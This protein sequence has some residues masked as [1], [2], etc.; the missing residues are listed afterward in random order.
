MN[1]TIYV[2]GNVCQAEIFELEEVNHY[3]NTS[4]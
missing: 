1:K 2:Y 4:E 3:G